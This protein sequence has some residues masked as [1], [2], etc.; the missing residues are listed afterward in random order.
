LCRRGD[1]SRV[2]NS[3]GWRNINTRRRD[4]TQS[5]YRFSVAPAPKMKI[6]PSQFK[7]WPENKLTVL[8]LCIKTGKKLY[9]PCP[10]NISF[11][12][13]IDCGK[14]KKKNKNQ[15]TKG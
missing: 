12:F 8:A 14:E 11:L 10:K 1:G 5:A 4:L 3:R 2:L 13:W 7:N 9:Y 15:I 6:L